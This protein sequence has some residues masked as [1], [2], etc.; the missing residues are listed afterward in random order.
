MVVQISITLSDFCF[1]PS[2][3][4]PCTGGGPA[5]Q[6]TYH[7]ASEAFASP[8]GKLVYYSKPS[9][10]GAIWSVP[11]EGGPEKLVPELARFDHIFRSWGVVQQGIYFI[12]KEQ[13]P[14]QMVH[15]FCFA[16]RRVTPLLTL[17]GEPAWDV[18]DVALSWDGR[19]LL[20]V[21]LD[22]KVDDLMLIKNFQ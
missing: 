16:T 4:P 12:S 11:A 18:P 10:W 2:L 22:R 1:A 6:L 19:R 15:F 21:R 5:M 9:P 13:R 7:G 8:D 20:V 3:Q 14:Q 17:N